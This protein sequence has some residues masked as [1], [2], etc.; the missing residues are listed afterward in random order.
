MLPVEA[1]QRHRRT[2]VQLELIARFDELG[3]QRRHQDLAAQGGRADASGEVDVLAEEV[4]LLLHGLAGVEPDADID[5]LV[6]AV[7]V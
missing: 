2:L 4:A 5:G 6:G 7:V 3:Q 1:L